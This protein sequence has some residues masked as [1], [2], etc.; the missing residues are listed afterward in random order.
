VRFAIIEILPEETLHDRF[1]IGWEDENVSERNQNAR[2]FFTVQKNC[3][4]LF[5]GTDRLARGAT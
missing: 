5:V 4:G 2:N 3:V 1:D